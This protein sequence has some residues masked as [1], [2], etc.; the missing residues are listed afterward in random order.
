MS[1]QRFPDFVGGNRGAAEQVLA[2]PDEF[3]ARVEPGLRVLQTGGRT[4]ARLADELR[5]AGLVDGDLRLTVLGVKFLYHADEHRRQATGDGIEEELLDRA[6]LGRTSR[7][8]DVGCGAGQTLRLLASRQPAERVGLDID[9]EALALGCH[10]SEAE[11]QEVRFVRGRADALPFRDGSF[12][13]VLCRGTISYLHQRRTL[14][15][16]TRVLRTGGFLYCRAEGPGYDMARLARATTG[17]Q[18]ASFLYDFLLGVGLA[19]TGWQAVPGRRG[20]GGRAFVTC[21]R[22]TKFLVRLGCRPVR[23][24][25]GPCYRGLPGWIEVLAEKRLAQDVD[26]IQSFAF[27]KGTPATTAGV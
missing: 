25:S 4:D 17:R 6:R 1:G 12:T 9:A 15:E 3:A 27:R 11:G 13:H 7:V 23:T 14:T 26:A 5:E 8:L 24:R 10:L 16:M 21:R 2:W 22:L 19:L 18:L 20:S